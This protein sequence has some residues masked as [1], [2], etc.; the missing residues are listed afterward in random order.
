MLLPPR[1]D[2]TNLIGYANLPN[3]SVLTIEIGSIVLDIKS[4]DLVIGNATLEN[5]TLK[6]GDNNHPISGV[7]DLATI[8]SN[9]GEVIKS[10]KQLFTTGD[11]N[12]ATVTRSVVWNGEEVPYYTEV[13]SE[14][15][16]VAHVPLIATLKNTFAHLNLTSLENYLHPSTNSSGGGLL[17]SGAF[18]SKSRSTA[19]LA[20]E[21]KQNVHVREAFGDEDPIKRDEMIDSLAGMYMKSS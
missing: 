5:F 17:G 13:M 1:P 11:L 20:S 10:Q 7:L 16:L 9:L 15:T 14:L 2:G 8:L 12:L 4:G 3:P 18:S 21:L 19:N 6:P